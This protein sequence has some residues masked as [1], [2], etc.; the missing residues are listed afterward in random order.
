MPHGATRARGI[1]AAI[2]SSRSILLVDSDPA[3][4]EALSGALH[5]A[6]LHV[7]DVYDGQTALEQLKSSTCDIMLA[8]NGQ[9]GMDSMRLLRRARAIRSDLKVIVAGERDPNRVVGAIRHRAFGYIHTPLTPGPV[10]E[11]VRQALG[12]TA[13]Q[14]DIRVIS[15]RPEWL[16]LDIRCKIDAV[17]RT[18]NYLKEI[19]ADLPPQV[20]DDIS[21]AYRELLMNAVEHGGRYDARKRVRTSLIRTAR[22]II[23]HIHDPGTGFSFDF[24]P[25]AAVSNPAE[26]PTRHVEIRAEKGQRPGGFG[27]LMS[28][29]LVDELLYNERGNAVLFVKYL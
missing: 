9:N 3:V 18:T 25:H 6:D 1:L 19:Q 27:I 5:A 20:C 2:V 17:E 11:M 16:T 15:A 22:S 21:V 13:W 26:S 28:R 14:D 8:G 23:V 7:E 12:A 4:H 29:T 10:A 24:L